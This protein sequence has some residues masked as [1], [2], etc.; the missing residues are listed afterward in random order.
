MIVTPIKTHKVTSEDSDITV[1]L[2]KYLPSLKE[3]SVIAI[4]SKVVAICEG[5][6]VKVDEVDKDELVKEE[7][8]YFLPKE[9]NK[10]HFFLT[11]KNNIMIASGGIDES[12]GNGY[13]ILWPKDSQESANTIR[14]FL[15]KEYGISEVGVIITDSKTTPL[16]RGVTGVTLAHSGFAALNDYIGHPDIFGRDLH[17][18]K[19]NIA[20]GLAGASVLS[21]GEGSEQTP[22]A[23]IE[24]VPFVTFQQRNPTV[25]ELADLRIPIEEDIYASILTRTPWQR[26][27]GK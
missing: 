14:E 7:V 3:R 8:E 23:V 1:L 21:M 4:T 24:D 16:R 27:K 11:I 25:E 20:D 22:F 18:T 10:Y 17:V 5:R 9:E 6:I 19:A 12:N 15:V 26:G 2:K 13:Y